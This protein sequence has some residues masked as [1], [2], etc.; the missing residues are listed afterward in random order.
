MQRLRLTFGRGDPLKYIAHLDLMRLWERL[1]RRA[2]VPL[3]YSKGFNPQPKIAI[4]APLPV[5]VT[6]EGEVLDV[7]LERDMTP[8]DFWQRLQ[9]QLPAGLEVY[10]VEE[11]SL[12]LPSL[13]SQLRAAEY[14]IAVA[15]AEGREA[16]EQ[17]IAALLQ[18]REL[19]RER[20]RHNE[21]RH[22]D[23]RPLIEQVWVETWDDMHLLGMRL[24][25]D[26]TAG[27][28]PEEVSDALG[29]GPRPLS[30]HRRRLV[31]ADQLLKEE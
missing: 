12:S 10:S 13:Q 25:A 5:G 17:R 26:P 20:R 27:G 29:F 1:L 4:A 22:Y 7:I 31:F 19:W 24:R 3:A 30:L 28:R 16:V 8:S 15:T 2:A 11:V 18:A 6:S 9:P 14:L 23:L 21:R